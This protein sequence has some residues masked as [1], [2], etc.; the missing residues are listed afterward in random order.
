MDW[1]N[2]GRHDLLVGDA[3][4]NIHIFK[5]TTDN[6]NPVLDSGSLLQVRGTAIN[7]GSRATPITDDWNGDG[8]KD[9]LVG[10]HSGNIYIFLNVGTDSEPI[11]DT[12]YFLQVAGRDFDVGARA[13]PRVFDW[14]K[15]GLKD[16]LVGELE[17]YIYYLK[18]VGTNNAPVFEKSEKLLLRSGDILRYP[19][20]TGYPRSRLFIT[21]WNNDGL[22]DILVGGI[23]GKIMLY[24][25]APRPSYSPWIFVKRMWSNLKESVIKLRK[26]IHK[27]Y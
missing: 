26:Q 4:G 27:Q 6:I 9:L 25:A 7:V 23:D 11:F 3:A 15:D 24:I 12:P 14:N 2:D 8:R 17:G 20:T 1:N 13:A 21:D 18:N 22:D 16:L 10:N 5:N 19:D